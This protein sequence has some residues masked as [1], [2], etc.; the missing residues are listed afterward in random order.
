MS[1]EVRPPHRPL[2]WWV[3]DLIAAV[4]IIA[5]AVAPYPVAQLRPSTPFAMAVVLAPVLLLPL[6]RLPPARVWTGVVLAACVALYGVAALTGIFAPGVVFAT[7]IAMFGLATRSTRRM[8][9]LAAGVAIVAVVGLNVLA[10]IGDVFDPRVLQ[11]AILLAFAAAAGDATRSRR[12]YIVAVTERAERAEQ[13]RE[14]EAR[15]RVS[16]ERLRIARDLHDAVA[17]QISVISLNAGVAS[18]ALDARPEAAR[19]ALASIRTASRAV[20]GEIGDLLAVLRSGEDA[21]PGEVGAPQPRLEGLH[22]LIEHF[23][24]AGLEITVRIEGD[25][26]RLPV[27]ADIVAYSVIQEGLTNASKHGSPR[28]AHLLV[29]VGEHAARIVVTNPVSVRPGSADDLPGGHGLLGLTERV[30]SVRGLVEAGATGAG[31]RLNA[32]LPLTKGEQP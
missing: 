15:R 17:H 24:A 2:P 30:A 6:R 22:D 32:V 29:S 3:G 14:S 25:L 12:E 16:E 20:L 10:A 26:G 21:A 23:R 9:L 1:I 7:A 11:F 13:T 8:T 18:S 28:R 19:E 31:Y 27:A 4:P 5:L